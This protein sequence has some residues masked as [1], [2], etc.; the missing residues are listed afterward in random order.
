MLFR[1]AYDGVYA[2]DW[3]D[4]SIVWKYKAPA[5]TAYESPYIDEAGAGVYSFNTGATIADGKMF[6]YNTEHT[7]SWPL[8]RGWGLHCINITN[9]ELV[10]KIGNPMSPGAIADGYLAAANS[11]DGYQYIFGKGKSETKVT[12]APKVITLG[13]E[14][15]IE[16]SVLDMSPAQ[17]GTPCVSP[18]SMTLQMEY[19]HLQQ[20]LHGLWGNESV[21]GVT[22]S[23]VTVDP[24]NNYRHIGEVN[25]DGYTGTFGFTWEPDVPGQYKITAQFLGDDSYS[26]SMATT[27]VEVVEAEPTITPDPVETVDYMPMMYAIL[28]VGIIA[29]I[30]G[31]LALFWKR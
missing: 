19:L 20:P 31:L 6:T 28:A 29:I 15:V 1:Q 9:G 13:D 8:T 11:R 18:E 14:I 26:S 24:N 5:K 4:G 3:D 12:L 17:P 25:T 16:G 10:W 21:S 7:E 27:Y 2:F 22:L 23:L 30:I